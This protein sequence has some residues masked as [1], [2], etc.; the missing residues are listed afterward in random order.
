MADIVNSPEIT[1]SPFTYSDPA[2]QVGC[3]VMSCSGGHEWTP[4]LQITQCPGCKS[5]IVAIKMVNC[6]NCN[7]PA[8]ALRLRSD[9]LSRGAAI[10]PICRGS[11]TQAEVITMDIELRHSA[12]LQA[13]HVERVLPSKI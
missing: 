12:I 2:P 8:V 5:P 3:S 13:N 1:P 7:E 11:A 6:P 10:T 4:T 9:H